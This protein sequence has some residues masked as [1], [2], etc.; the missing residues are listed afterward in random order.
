[1]DIILKHLQFLDGSIDTASALE[2]TYNPLLVVL[3][4]I[5][6]CMAAFSALKIVGRINAAQSFVVKGVWLTIGA[7]IMGIGVWAMH[8][9]A[10]VA[11]ILPVPVGYSIPI[12]I[13]SV[14]PS[15]FA[16]AVMLHV[17]S[18]DKIGIQQLLLGGTLMG[19][20]I[21]V[22]HY[23][24]MAAMQMDALMLYDPLLF[25]VSVIVAVVLATLALYTK[26]FAGSNLPFQANW[27][28]P[29]AALIMGFAVS[30]M[31]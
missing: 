25:I 10:M 2:S 7:V 31:H 12:T 19:A 16:S 6:A 15:I 18:R 17:I 11:F 23:T 27:R 5:T 4:I 20:G 14:F 21:G 26:S 1:M 8:F 24:G 22:M 29:V 30:G 28:E 9:V 13:I 3:S